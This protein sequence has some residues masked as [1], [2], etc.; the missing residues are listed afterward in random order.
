MPIYTKDINMNIRTKKKLQLLMRRFYGTKMPCR[1]IQLLLNLSKD[2][3]RAHIDSYKLEG[4]FQ[5]NFGTY[6][7]L[8]HIVPAGLFDIDNIEERKICYSYINIMPME[9]MDNRIKGA[10]IHFSLEKIN[11]LLKKEHKEEVVIILE[12]LKE[13]CIQEIKNRY[14]KYL[15]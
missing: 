14:D 2:E 7:G 12:I 6:W 8:D 11:L 3:F 13:R 10:S 15:I 1:E 9:N 4:M 5:E